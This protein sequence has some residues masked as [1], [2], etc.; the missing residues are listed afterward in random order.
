L[1]EKIPFTLYRMR[2]DSFVGC[3]NLQ[4]LYV[5]D[6]PLTACLFRTVSPVAQTGASQLLNFQLLLENQSSQ[7]SVMSYVT[8][9]GHGLVL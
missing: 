7:P 8:Q 9:G 3:E 2:A 5:M 1:Q 4:L 6:G